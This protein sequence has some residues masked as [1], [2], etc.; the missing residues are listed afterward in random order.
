MVSLQDIQTARQKIA[1]FIHKT[2][3]IHSNSLSA[4][5]G[6]EVW[7]KLENL[8]K[9]GSFKV[10]GA[11]NKLLHV[12]EER[13]IAASMGNHAQAVAFAANKLQKKATIVMPATV[14]LVKEEATKGYGAEV[15]LTGDRLSD[16]L[17]Y[18]QTQKDHVFIHPFDDDEVIA[19][20]GTIG[21]E[22]TE[23]LEDIDVVIVPVGGGGLIGGIGAAVKALSPKTRVI[24]VQAENAP[25]AA[26]SFR[27][28]KIAERVPSPTIADGIAVGKIGVKTFE[29]IRD[30]VDDMLLVNEDEIARAILLFLERKK[31]VVEGAGAVTLAALLENKEKFQD[32]RIVLVL[33]GGNIDFTV[34]DR[35]IRKGLVTSRRT[36]VFEVTVADIPGSLHTVTGVL[37][38]RRANIL[39]VAHDRLAADTPF[40][41]T[42]VVFTV[43][44][45]GKKHLEDILS[46]LAGQGYEVREK[47]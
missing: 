26:V 45:R 9:T 41:K 20:Q 42:K 10:R 44:I 37:A 46:A 2:P 31:L 5:S 28:G 13:V 3:L 12:R 16:A 19:G 32:K 1:S 14:S 40:G 21:L 7:L 4:M 27:D 35:I 38:S 36:G 6:A 34:V 25:S 8:Q 15:V 39:D 22:I 23:E 17:A 30:R 18:A 11:F 33:S 47:F 43:E 29:V 24:G